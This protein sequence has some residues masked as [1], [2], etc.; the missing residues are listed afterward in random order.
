MVHSTATRTTSIIRALGWVAIVLSAILLLAEGASRLA[1]LTQDP[2]PTD[3]VDIRYV[4]HPP[5]QAS[6]EREG[7]HLRTMGVAVSQVGV[8]V[9]SQS[10][11]ESFAS[12]ASIL[13]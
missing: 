9:G 10:R 5:P 4:Q 13:S 3:V 2:P 6:P 12:S 8:G 11:L 7:G 1:D